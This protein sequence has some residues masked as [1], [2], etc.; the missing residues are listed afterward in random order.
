LIVNVSYAIIPREWFCASY[1]RAT[2]R[3]RHFDTCHIPE[4]PVKTTAAFVCVLALAALILGGCST[5]TGPDPIPGPEYLDRTSVENVLHN[6]RLAYVE[7]DVEEYLDCL[8]EDFIFYPDERDVQDPELEIPPEWYK[9]DERGMH[10]NMFSED[11]NVERITLTLTVVSM[12]YEEGIPADETDDIYICLLD[13]DLRVSVYGNLT[14]L[15]TGQSEYLLRIDQDQAGPGGAYLWEI[16][17]WFDVGD[18][19]RGVSTAV[20]DAT[21]GGVKAMYR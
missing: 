5:G 19:G 16:Y 2:S 18:P 20:E 21:W 14:Y 12:E 10:E 3:D 17:M 13:V 7:R 1:D 8:S 4:V 6:I 11:S 15:V 9:T